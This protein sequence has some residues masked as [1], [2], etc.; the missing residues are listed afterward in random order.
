MPITIISESP[1]P[2]P[3]IHTTAGSG[4]SWGEDGTIVFAPGRRGGLYLIPAAGGTPK[5]LATPDSKKGESSYRWPYLLPGGGEV[6][7]SILSSNRTDVQIVV[8]SLKTGE[9][10]VLVRGAGVARYVP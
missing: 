8:Q 7:F 4:A 3:E 1:S 6:L 10:R 9:R 2:C 5:L